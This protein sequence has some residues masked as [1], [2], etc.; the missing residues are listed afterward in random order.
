MSNLFLMLLAF[1]AG[2]TAPT[3]A[4]INAQLELHWAKSSSL[5]SLVSFSV[6]TVCM[7]VYCLLTRITFPL[8]GS[9]TSHWWHWAGGLLGAFFVTTTIYVAPRLG[10]VSMVA[11]LLAGQM[12]ASIL[13]DH[14]GLLGYAE[15]PISL[16]RLLGIGMLFGGVLLIRRF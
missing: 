13:L 5:A 10:A 14:F 3:Q 15:K 9:G 7:L 4:G 6:G 12:V 1:I 11:L 2:A 16:M 8:L